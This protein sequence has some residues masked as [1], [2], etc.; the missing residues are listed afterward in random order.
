MN[1][2][3]VA[4]PAEAALIIYDGNCFFCQNYARL[5]RLRET[6][7]PVELLDARSGDPRIADWW[8]KGYDLNAGMLFVHQGRV[9]HGHEAVQALAALSGS[10]TPFNRLNRL[11]LSNAR[12][13]RLAYPLLKLARRASLAVRGRP[14][15]D[16]PRAGLGR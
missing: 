8:R 1:A 4:A 11:A 14:L 2:E 15:L 5:V 3:T 6:V 12:V 16:D 7:G 9:F 10:S 13:A